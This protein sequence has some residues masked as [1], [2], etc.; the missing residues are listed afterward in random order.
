ML[1]FCP[2]AVILG[3]NTAAI[4]IATSQL[5]KIFGVTA[6]KG[7]RHYEFV[8]NTVRAAME[9]THWPTFGMA[10]I[11]FAIIFGVRRY[12]PTLPSVL[13]AVI[14]TTILAWLFASRNT[15]PSN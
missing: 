5:G 13:I 7:E 10:V 9:H 1:N 11:A 8:I 15:A 4:I 3:A 2:I 14:V 12:K 6:E